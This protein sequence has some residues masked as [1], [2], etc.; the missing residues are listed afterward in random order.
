M[1]TY[2]MPLVFAIGL[3]LPIMNGCAG[4]GEIVTLDVGAIPSKPSGAPLK[5]EMKALVI[6]FEDQRPEKKAIGSRTH[7]GGGRTYFTVANNKPG[8]VIAQ[9][10]AD[11]LKQKGWRTWVGPSGGAVVA[12]PAGGLDVILNGQVLEL[13][14]NAKSK[15]GSTDMTVKTKVAIQA[16]NTKDGSTARMTLNGSRS[17]SVF[18][19][20]PE[21]L[22]EAIN[23]MLKESVERLLAD[24]KVEN[25]LLQVQ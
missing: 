1:N 2:L 12:N 8:D 5:D 3:A 19:F 17:Q 13:S 22:Q 10:L 9:V 14:A 7:L 6:T 15:F 21:D 24:A 23:Q 4:K 11:Y 16:Q 20:E 18:W 25:K